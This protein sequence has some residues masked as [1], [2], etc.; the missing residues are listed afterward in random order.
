MTA[1][2]NP[3]ALRN[4]P[5]LCF[6]ALTKGLDQLTTIRPRVDDEASLSRHDIGSI[7]RNFENSA[8]GNE[9]TIAAF[10]QAACLFGDEGSR[11][12]RRN[13]GIAA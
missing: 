7:R 10:R 3:A 13:E 8:R 5:D 9:M 2:F 4:L 12:G 6:Q 1:A 11:F